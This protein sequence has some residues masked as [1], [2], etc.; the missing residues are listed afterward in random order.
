[1]HLLLIQFLLE[2]LVEIL[3]LL[4]SLK[5]VAEA[6]AAVTQVME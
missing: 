1:M 2:L 3:L 4:V 5:M 6:E